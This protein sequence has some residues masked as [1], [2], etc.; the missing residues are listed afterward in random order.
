MSRAGFTVLGLAGGAKELGY[1]CESS[2]NN[3]STVNSQHWPPW[4]ST[5][6]VSASYLALDGLWAGKSLFLSLTNAYICKP[7][8]I[9]F[10]FQPWTA[11]LWSPNRT[12]PGREPC[13][14][15]SGGALLGSFPKVL[16]VELGQKC[17]HSVGGMRPS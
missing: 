2:Q 4:D 1:A 16:L 10:P 6:L 17:C 3:R 11:P 7:N 9:K 13:L 8:S 12:A 14:G 15:T 5:V